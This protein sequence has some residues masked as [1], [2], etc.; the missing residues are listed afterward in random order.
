MGSD[1]EGWRG[2][3]GRKGER[4]LS[5]MEIC[6]FGEDEGCSYKASNTEIFQLLINTC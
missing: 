6:N 1:W 2:G 3:D 5:L 4:N